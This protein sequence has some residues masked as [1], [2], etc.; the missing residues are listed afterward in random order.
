MPKNEKND[1][2]KLSSSPTSGK[3]SSSPFR[4]TF[5][6]ESYREK[7]EEDP[8]NEGAQAMLELFKSLRARVEEQEQSEEWRKLNL[9]AD[10]RST[11]WILAKV[12]E[13]DTYAQNLYAALCNNDFQKKEVWSVL[14]DE[15]WSCSWRYAGGIIADMRR[16]G[17]YINWYGLGIGDGLGNGDGDGSKGYVS[18]GIVTEEI[19]NDLNKLGW[20]VVTSDDE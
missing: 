20:I 3:L 9:E 18:E 16:E 11:D 10:L 8:T 15:T 19:E 17:D 4:G 2:T 5:Q 13:S 12:R 14:K 7:L 1:L 6:Q